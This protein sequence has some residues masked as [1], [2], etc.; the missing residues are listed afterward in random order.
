MDIVTTANHDLR[1]GAEGCG[2]LAS[3]VCVDHE[4]SKQGEK[5]PLIGT[6]YMAQQTDSWL[7]NTE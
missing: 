2:S 6:P 3:I 4:S 1:D 5:G 7:R